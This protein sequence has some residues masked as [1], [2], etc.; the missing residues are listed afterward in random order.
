MTTTIQKNAKTSKPGKLVSTGHVDQLIRTYKKER[1]LANTKRLG[2]NDSLS[3]WYGLDELTAFLQLAKEHQAD[4]VKMYFGVYPADYAETPEFQGR[5]TVVLVATR[6]KLTEHGTV[7]KDIYMDKGGAPEILAF[8]ASE[9]C[10]PWCGTGLP[11][12]DSDR[13]GFDMEKIG[14]SVLEHQDTIKVI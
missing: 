2:K 14:L 3:T 6:Q 12:Y 10:P 7:N 11:P 1:W 8:N 4:G 9:I 13:L 5:Q